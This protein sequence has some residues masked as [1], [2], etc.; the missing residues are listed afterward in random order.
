MR[1]SAG[2]RLGKIRRQVNHFSISD[3]IHLI[4]ERIIG[5]FSQ[6]AQ[7]PNY[8][9]LPAFDAIRS[10]P[11][12][13]ASQKTRDY[14]EQ[15]LVLCSFSRAYQDNNWKRHLKR[16]LPIYIRSSL[17][18]EKRPTSK[19]KPEV[20]RTL[21]M[22][23]PRLV[24]QT[25]YEAIRLTDMCIVDW[26]EWRPNV[27]FELG[28]RVSSNN[29]GPVCIIEDKHREFIEEVVQNPTNAQ[30][31]KRPHSISDR[32][33]ARLV[34]AA[35]QYRELLRM[36]DP[37]E[38]MAPTSQEQGGEDQQAYT[39]MVAFHK[40]LISTADWKEFDTMF[41]PN[42]TY[43]LITEWID[44]KVET[45]ARPVYIE[46]VNAANLL[47]NPEIDSHGM[48]PVLYPKNTTL[49]QKADEGALERRI[50]AWLYLIYRYPLEDISNDPQLS[51]IFTRLG[52]IV[53]PALLRSSLQRDIELGRIIRQQTRTLRKIKKGKINDRHS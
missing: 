38:Y 29:L 51:R 5:G 43:N 13:T 35:S 9:D 36:F 25:L 48:S 17:A 20:L 52:N 3:P 44:W 19:E 2:A 46:L 27:F 6:L 8:L 18:K 7:L 33:V 31:L 32:D 41:A 37:I 28:V 4:G 21:D 49:I 15:V 39:K 53:A 40:N 10:L 30:A 1:R 14:T 47:S 23:S 22:K 26:T 12:E 42:K 50:A 16:N 34:N 11:P 24:S 45:A